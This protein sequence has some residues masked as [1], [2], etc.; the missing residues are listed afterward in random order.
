MVTGYIVVVSLVIVKL[1]VLGMFDASALAWP[2]RG[3]TNGGGSRDP[4]R[5]NMLS[6]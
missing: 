2:Q 5:P 4:V 1:M 3:Y 6:P